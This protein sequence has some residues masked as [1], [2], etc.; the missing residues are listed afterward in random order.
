MEKILRQTGG[1]RRALN[2]PSFKYL[3]DFPP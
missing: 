1:F 3:F 2:E